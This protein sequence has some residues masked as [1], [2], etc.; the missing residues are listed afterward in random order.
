MPKQAVYPKGY[1]PSKNPL[2]PGIRSHH[3]LFVS[4]QVGR[5]SSGTVPNGVKAQTELLLK[6]LQ[7]VV[8][9]AGA[10]MNDV[11]RCTCYLTD[12]ADFPAFNEV[13]RTFFADPMPTRSTV[14]VSKLAGLGFVV[15]V[16]A[17]AEVEE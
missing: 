12:I 4:G 5:D 14:E 3:L 17:V 16:D 7:A 9:A 10:T 8:E 11:V 15:E 6:N 1:V 13:Y 2:S